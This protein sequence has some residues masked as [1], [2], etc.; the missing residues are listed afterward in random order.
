MPKSKSS[1]NPPKKEE[2]GV[3][4]GDI[5]NTSTGIS[6]SIVSGSS[7][8]SKGMGINFGS[9]NDIFSWKKTDKS[10]KLKS[11]EATKTT[12]GYNGSLG[13]NCDDA[14]RTSDMDQKKRKKV[15]S[16]NG[17]YAREISKNMY[18]TDEGDEDLRNDVY[19]EARNVNPRIRPRLETRRDKRMREMEEMA[20]NGTYR[21]M[22]LFDKAIEDIE[23]TWSLS[24]SIGVNSTSIEPCSMRKDACSPALLSP[25]Y[26]SI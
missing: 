25:H 24:E 7:D 5:R 8:G 22:S 23:Q 6:G 1:Y 11:I 9:F 26:L 2:K 17:R 21:K 19:V 13:D 3:D 20:R 12:E 10:V 4:S 16:K 14:G 15:G 18:R